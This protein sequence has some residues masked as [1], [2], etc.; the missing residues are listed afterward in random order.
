MARTPR[1]Q[2]PCLA[3]R[4]LC[5]T[6]V[7]EN[8]R[9]GT[10]VNPRHYR[11]KP[12]PADHAC[13]EEEVQAH[14]SLED[15]WHQLQ[16]NTIENLAAQA[17]IQ[18]AALDVVGSANARRKRQREEAN[19]SAAKRYKPSTG[20]TD[21]LQGLASLPVE[22]QQQAQA[23]IDQLIKAH[24][25]Q[26]P[27]HAYAAIAAPPTPTPTAS[28]SS[29][30]HLDEEEPMVIDPPAHPTTTPTGR[31][32]ILPVRPHAAAS[33]Q[34]EQSELIQEVSPGT[35]R[36]LVPV[37]TR[38]D[39][40]PAAAIGRRGAILQRLQRVDKAKGAVPVPPLVP[41]T[42]APEVQGPSLAGKRG[43]SRTA[44]SRKIAA[45]NPELVAAVASKSPRARSV[46]STEGSV[47]KL[48]QLAIGQTE[49]NRELFG[50]EISEDEEA[51]LL[52][53]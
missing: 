4:S 44:H 11:L 27:V 17:T 45:P 43:K 9:L 14:R 40:Q 33:T 42:P 49:K 35:S 50:G 25:Q 3:C 21:G 6:W 37:L 31:K 38:I 36:Q 15:E 16:Q 28:S 47:P 41:A 39:D 48:Q 13:N 2:Y 7:G 1:I 51:D 32:V 23:L 12:L 24:Q 26:L 20:A 8:L 18:K 34:G 22:I 10:S 19:V 30:A 5:S 53:D 29:A 46:S 52:A